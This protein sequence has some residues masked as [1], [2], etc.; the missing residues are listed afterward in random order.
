[1][2]VSLAMAIPRMAPA[3]MVARYS[4][5]TR[6]LSMNLRWKKL[7]NGKLILEQYIQIGTDRNGHV[8]FGWVEVETVND[9]K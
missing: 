9:D 6:E 3:T 7:R 8:I 5:S 1:M 2:V 4:I